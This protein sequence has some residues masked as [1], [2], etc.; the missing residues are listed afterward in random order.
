MHFSKIAALA[1]AFG[2]LVSAHPGHDH[3]AELA[4]RAAILSK[5]SRKDLSHC[6][7]K[8]K[9]RGIEARSIKRRNA[10]AAEILKRSNI[11]RDVTEVLATSHHSSESYTLATP[12]STIFATNNSCVLSPEV[13]EGPYYVAGEYIRQNVIESQAG[14]NLTL[15]IQVLDTETCEPVTGAYLEIWHCNSTGVYSGVSA[16]GN[17]NSATDTSNLDATFLRGV[18]LTDSDGTVQF[19]TLFPGHYTGR[20]NHI[21]VMVHMN[22][23]ATTTNNTLLDT[24][25]VGHVG[26]I[27]F[28]QDL[29]TQVEATSVYAANTQTLTTNDEDGIL[30]QEAATS[31]P[32]MEYVLLGSSVDEAGLLGWIS[33]GINTTLS[34]EVSAA[35]TLYET[36]G[37]TNAGSGVGGGPGGP[38]SGTGVPT[39]GVPTGTGAP[40]A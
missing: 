14:V 11:K 29:V 26:Q 28:D 16:S 22:A 4:E 7:A 23:T 32:L 6:A 35:A 17:G 37:Q 39:G 31:D 12:E 27:F 2:P 3:K 19:D 40:T 21:H 10:L 20:T 24:T 34:K 33:F 25:H 30:T 13:T 38:P 8:L 5:L 36:G 1:A 18:Q 9:A 15:D